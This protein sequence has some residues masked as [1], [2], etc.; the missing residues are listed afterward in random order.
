MILDCLMIEESATREL[1]ELVREW[2]EAFS[3]RDFDAAV[4]F[5]APDGVFEGKVT[6]D[7]CE[8]RA[9]IRGFFEGF[10]AT[11][12]E[13]EVESTEIFDL[14]S[15]ACVTRTARDRNPAAPASLLRAR[16]AIARGSAPPHP[17]WAGISDV[18]AAAAK[19]LSVA[20]PRQPSG[21]ARSVYEQRGQRPAASRE[22]E[23]GRALHEQREQRSGGEQQ[24]D[25][26]HQQ[27]AQHDPRC[28]PRGL[29]PRQPAAG[30]DALVGTHAVLLHSNHRS[31][32]R[33]ESQEF[34][35]GVDLF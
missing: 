15:R 20:A 8:G 35:D 23:S 16:V 9:A 33:Q 12:E 6:G 26:G 21:N 31:L 1:V 27:R 32:I 4:S 29:E 2:N 5:Y 7:R 28:G 14:G 13:Y 11:F 25:I 18:R 19:H 22:H 34:G 10:V 30:S 17:R 24:S 3:R